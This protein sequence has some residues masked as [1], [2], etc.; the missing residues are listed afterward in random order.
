M[1]WPLT[2]KEVRGIAI[3][4]LQLTMFEDFLDHEDPPVRRLRA[5]FVKG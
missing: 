4:N 2:A 3:A 1:P 5:T